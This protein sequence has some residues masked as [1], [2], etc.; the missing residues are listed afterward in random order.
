MFH[1]SLKTALVI[2]QSQNYLTSNIL[3]LGI[4]SVALTIY[5]V[6]A[7]FKSIGRIFVVLLLLALTISETIIVIL[8]FTV[9][10]RTSC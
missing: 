7:V 4:Q 9:N 8:L 1:N 2:V 5:T 10:L 6:I 3:W